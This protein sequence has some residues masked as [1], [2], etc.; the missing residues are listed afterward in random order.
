MNAVGEYWYRLTPALRRRLVLGA[1]GREQLFALGALAP[2]MATDFLV[3]AWTDCPLDGGLA[4]TLDAKATG[5]RRFL[6]GPFSDLLKAQA[7][8]WSPPGEDDPWRSAAGEQRRALL[9]ERLSAEPKNLF[10]KLAAWEAAWPENDWELVDLSLAEAAWPRTL[11]PLRHRYAAQ[12]HLCRG[13]AYAA[14]ASLNAAAPLDR[15]V[16]DSPLR[17]T[18]LLRMGRR[19]E[20][21]AV[22]REGVKR[23]PWRVNE[24]LRLSDLVFGVETDVRPVPGTCAILLY[25]W[26][27]AAE[28]D[29]TLASIAAS[30][31][32]GAP[33]FVLDNGSTDATPQVLTAWRVRLRERI[34]VVTLP[35]NIGAPAA[36]NWLLSLPEVRAC[37]Y[38]AFVDDDVSLPPDWLL[39]LG[40][41]VARVPDASVWGCRVV[42]DACPLVI[43][44]VDYTPLAPRPGEQ[45]LVL[46]NL[47]QGAP[48]LGRFDYLRP[49]VSV[50][51]CCHLL[52]TADIPRAGTF[53]IRFSPSQYDDLER[54]LRVFLAGGFAAYQGH[55]AVRHKRRSG[56]LAQRSEAEIGGATANAHKL[57]TKHAP[58]DFQALHARGAELL[59]RD[60][61][62]RIAEL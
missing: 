37:D 8:F 15:F 24:L 33:I 18:C 9:R 21:V 55:L 61:L 40:A 7:S 39:R 13:D 58:A 44:N 4:K 32:G 1:V 53:D 51:G 25:S 22:L 6:P 17:A 36:R 52:R 28:L 16:D 50:T 31:A 14:L 19:D 2:V 35:V 62:R 45:L 10:W 59:V 56:A 11:T 54:D 46:A 27:K 42:D 30:D 41:A 57:Q 20:A 26:N 34:A 43:Q 60:L 29:A 23:S 3:A 5:Q 48:D 49:C 12:V 38:A 47:H